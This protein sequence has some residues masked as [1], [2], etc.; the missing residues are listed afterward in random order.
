[1]QINRIGKWFASGW[2]TCAGWSVGSLDMQ[3]ETTLDYQS[4]FADA[5]S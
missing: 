1:M 3:V 5:E 2:T 4:Q